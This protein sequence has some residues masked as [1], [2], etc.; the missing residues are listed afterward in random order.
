MLLRVGS[1]IAIHA[2]LPSLNDIILMI[3]LVLRPAC[4]QGIKSDRGDYLLT[5]KSQLSGGKW[6]TLCS[7]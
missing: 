7:L 3:T 1:H 5:T 4:G 2:K 6:C